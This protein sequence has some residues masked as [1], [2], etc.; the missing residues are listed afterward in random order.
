VFGVSFADLDYDA[1]FRPFAKIG[2]KFRIGF[3][4]FEK[5]AG[6]FNSFETFS[7]NT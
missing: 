1:I 4:A 6:Q 2:D 5:M 7:T 3:V